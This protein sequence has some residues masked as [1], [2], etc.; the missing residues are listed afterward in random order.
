MTIICTKEKLAEM[1]YDKRMSMRQISRELS[2]PETNVWKHMTLYGLKRRE[3]SDA[4]K[5]ITKSLEH[6][7]KLADIRFSKGYGRGELNHLWTGGSG[8]KLNDRNQV[9]IVY[10]KNSVKRRDKFTCQMCGVSGL[11]ECKCCGSK[12]TLHAHHIKSWKDHP[13]LR[14]DVSNGITLCDKCHRGL[15]RITGLIA[16][17]SLKKDNQQPS[18]EIANRLLEGSTVSPDESIMDTNAPLERDDMTCSIQ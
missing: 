1:Y 17:T 12:P 2:C 14:F 15:N 18:Q 9:G 6:R 8:R 13:E 3:R 4:M 7:Q 11:V 16:G 10:W 5:M